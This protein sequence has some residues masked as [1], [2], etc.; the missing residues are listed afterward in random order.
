MSDEEVLE[1]ASAEDRILITNDKDFGDKVYRDGFPHRGI[2]LLR[3][4]DE[5][6]ASKVAVLQKL[7]TSHADDLAERFVV[8]TETS[9]RISPS[10]SDHT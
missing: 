7:L 10:L 6:A 4:D 5:R 1:Q 2:V 3:L 9:I 8:A